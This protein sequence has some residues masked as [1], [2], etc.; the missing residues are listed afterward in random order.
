MDVTYILT[1]LFSY[2]LAGRPRDLY[3]T[4][5]CAKKPMEIQDKNYTVEYIEEENKITFKGNLRLKSVEEYNQIMDFIFNHSLTS[6]K[7]LLLDMTKLNVINSAGIASIG[8]FL[9]KMR[10]HNKKIK[11]LAS[12]YTHWQAVS[13]KDFTDI[14]DNLEIEYIVHH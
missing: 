11:I 5:E 1:E 4:E 6:G 3:K 2:S 14:N 8:L 10:E 7:I 9:I 12:K 13:L